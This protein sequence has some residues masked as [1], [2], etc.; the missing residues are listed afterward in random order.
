MLFFAELPAHRAGKID[1][2]YQKQFI[3]VN[4]RIGDIQVPQLIPRKAW[5]CKRKWLAFEHTLNMPAG[6]AET[7]AHAMSVISRKQT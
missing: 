7:Q 1:W 4:M 5:M 3:N 2:S 6:L